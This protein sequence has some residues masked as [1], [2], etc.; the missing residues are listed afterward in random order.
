MALSVPHRKH[1]TSPLRVQQVNAIY[2]FVTIMLS[3]GLWRWYINI[4]IPILDIIHYPVFYTEREGERKL[5]GVVRDTTIVGGGSE[6][7]FSVWRF[8]GIAR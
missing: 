2:R 3:I 8:P 4:I 1:N 5:R 6:T 7:I